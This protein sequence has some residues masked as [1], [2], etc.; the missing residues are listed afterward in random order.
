MQTTFLR[1]LN[2]PICAA[3]ATA[4]IVPRKNRAEILDDE[5]SGDDVDDDDK[6]GEGEEED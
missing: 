5:C 6:E 3:F 1:A 2:A 4:T